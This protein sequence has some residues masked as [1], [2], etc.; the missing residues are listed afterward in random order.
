M[1]GRT[2]YCFN[3]VCSS[4]PRKD[5]KQL[6]DNIAS[7]GRQVKNIKTALDFTIEAVSDMI[8]AILKHH[9]AF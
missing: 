7:Y 9:Q 1:I 5:E 4:F 2:V 6:S 8:K 3:E